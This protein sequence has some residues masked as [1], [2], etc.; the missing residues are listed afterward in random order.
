MKK[1][2]LN[3][4][5][6]LLINKS[7]SQQIDFQWVKGSNGAFNAYSNS[8]VVDPLGNVYT[9]G[10]FTGVNDFDPGPSSYTLMSG[11]GLGVNNAFISKLDAN[12]NFL[13][14]KKLGSLSFADQCN[15][16]SIALDGLGNVYTTGNYI[17][18]V[19]F[20]PS[21][22]TFTLASIAPPSLYDFYISKLDANGN[23][24]WAKS[25]GGNGNDYG[26]SI[27]IDGSNNVYTSGYFDNT[28]DFDPNGGIFNLTSSGLQDIFISKLDV[29]GNFIWAKNMGGTGSDYCYAIS[30]DLLGNSYTTGSFNGISDFDPSG[31]GTY[32]LVSSGASDVFISKL[33]AS[34]S[35]VWAKNIGGTLADVGNSIVIDGANNV[36]TTGSYNGTADFDPAGTTYTLTSN[37]NTDIF[38]SKLDISGNFVW[39]KSMGG[40]QFDIGNSITLDMSSNICTTGKF[41]ST[42]CDFDPGPGS[43]PISTTGVSY[44][45][46]ISKLNPLGDFIFAKSMGS[47]SDDNGSSIKISNSDTTYLTGG[48]VGTVDFDPEGGI[49]TITGTGSPYS[50]FVSK[51]SPCASPTLTLT[52]TNYSICI[53]TTST[54]TASGA[55]TYTW[56]TGAFTSSISVNPILPTTYT[57]I[58]ENI[59]GC[60]KTKTISISINPNPTIL[61]SASPATICAFSSSTLSTTGAN[62]Y[63][64]NTGVNTTSIVST[65]TIST[66][67]TVTGTSVLGCISSKTINLSVIPSTFITGMVT[68]TA[69]IPVSGLV[70][71]YLNETG[72]TKYD[73]IT[74]IA[75][76]GSGAYTFT[77]AIN[78]NKY[79]IKAFPLA[80][81]YMNTYGNSSSFWKGATP[82][83]HGCLSTSTV[84][85]TVLDLTPITAGI[86]SLSG[87]IEKGPGYGLRTNGTKPL[88][89]P[90]R[91]I[92]VKG[93]RNP[94]GNIVAQTTT[95][96]NGTYTLSGLPNDNYFILVDIP[97]LDTNGTYH[98]V[99]L[100]GSEIY[101]NLDFTVDSTKINPINLTVGMQEINIA[102]NNISIFPNPT[103]NLIN[104]HFTLNQTSNVK[105]ELFDLLGKSIKTIIELNNQLSNTYETSTSLLDLDSGI[106][107]I[108]I[109]LNNEEQIVKI[110]IS[111]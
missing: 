75:I 104:I 32:N 8:V 84:N 68:N 101:T 103:S 60:A 91:G 23:F 94:G 97:G 65:V 109:T 28:V 63:T 11:N 52:A 77:N 47:G 14:A 86:G 54:I 34:G 41:N 43:Y 105:F 39:S 71:L 36:Y 61:I 4:F 30:L 111:K 42:G 70:T 25:I 44:D 53:G 20:D 21:L 59:P 62:T 106:Y 15:G 12:G 89:T 5:L 85:I 7:F 46:F 78:A 79:L 90:I 40:G 95:D 69:S 45:I 35:F 33:D 58:A 93:G 82:I 37:G 72:Y 107:F 74:S 9:T 29:N 100:T 48:F 96:A 38:V 66:N 31:I 99:L 19:D 55:L 88:G 51:F 3:I 73:S 56:S 13:W 22:S 64:W 49:T 2:F 102:N 108:K 57:V 18:T 98:K 80:P 24:L 10:Y 87:K 83:I 16:T 92:S 1:H 6:V 17:G 67:Y 76:S 110:C 50:S 26:H 27:A 81:N